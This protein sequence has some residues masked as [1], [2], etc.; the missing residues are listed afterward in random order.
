MRLVMTMTAA[1]PE[2]FPQQKR[3]ESRRNGLLPC[4]QYPE[5][6]DAPPSV[7]KPKA[8]DD[9]DLELDKVAAA[10]APLASAENSTTSE[11]GEEDQQDVVKG[12]CCQERL[13]GL[14]P[15]QA[16][17]AFYGRT[18]AKWPA[19]LAVIALTLAILGVSI[20]G[21][22]YIRHEFDPWLFLP[23]DSYLTHFTDTRAK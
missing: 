23:K 6:N 15:L 2:I 18:I 3:Q 21:S 17:F 13:Q 14:S 10:T 4:I 5:E 8:D 12:N 11:L 20:Y 9:V 22:Y 16:F 19:K 7:T 1:N